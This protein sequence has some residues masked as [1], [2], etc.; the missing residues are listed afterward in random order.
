M[1]YNI[2]LVIAMIAFLGLILFIF[3]FTNDN[4]I[5]D[6]L[7]TKFE[8]SP[9]IICQGIV[10]GENTYN[11]QSN[12]DL[13]ITSILVKKNEYVTCNQVLIVL[14]NA[15]YTHLLNIEKNNL[16]KNE[17]LLKYNKS[18]LE[19]YKYLRKHNSI[20]Q[21]DLEEQELKIS[22][23]EYDIK[24]NKERILHL[25]SKISDTYIKSP[26]NGYVIDIISQV[27]EIAKD[28]LIQID[29]INNKHVIG[30]VDEFQALNISGNRVSIKADGTY[31]TFFGTI[32][33]LSP[34]MIQKPII[35]NRVKEK[36]DTL[37]REMYIQLD[38]NYSLLIKN[39]PVE[40]T[41]H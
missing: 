38:Q 34:I 24:E 29:S 39:L 1:W 15:E 36:N 12:L 14:H 17:I 13:K 25:N 40:I 5:K 3:Y 28:T 20:S 30:Y 4:S 21:I 11:I 19:T 22:S 32:D 33:W 16:E 6:Y 9:N 37:V 41:I 2:C 8:N 18:R 31:E 27:G 35:R 26:C 23:I 10:S 7:P